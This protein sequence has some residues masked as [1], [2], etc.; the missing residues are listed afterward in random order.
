MK[1]AIRFTER[2]ESKALPIL[3]GHSPG[4]ISP[5]RIYVLS[6]A[7]VA[8]LRAAGVRFTLLARESSRCGIG[9]NDR[10]L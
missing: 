8:A 6:D 1:V 7:A 2:Q 10:V 5:G 9:P 3:L 4:M